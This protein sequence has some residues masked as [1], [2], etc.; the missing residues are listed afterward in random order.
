MEGGT[1]RETEEKKQ[2]KVWK[3]RRVNKLGDLDYRLKENCSS[4]SLCL[5]VC[6]SSK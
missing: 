1:E 3:R 4:V 5:T 2:G 6:D